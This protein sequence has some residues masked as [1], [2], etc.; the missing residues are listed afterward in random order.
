MKGKLLIK[1]RRFLAA[2]GASAAVGPFF[3]VTPAKADK[4]ELVVVSWG[5]TWA[6][7]MREVMFAPF[8]R[9]TGFKVRDDGPPEGAKL[10]AMIQGGNVTWDVLDTDLPAIQTMVKDGL[11]DALDYS[12]LAKA[13]LDHIPKVL[14]SSHAVGHKIYSF[15]IVYNTK[16]FPTGK[17]PKSW[18][19]VW[20]G[21]KFKGGRS[22]AFRGGISPQ[23][24]IALLADGV[25]I[26][27][28]NPLDVER[29]WKSM[30][31]L[32]PL[33]TKWYTGHAEAI[34]LVS[35]GEVDIACTVGPRGI[36]AK[37]AGAPVDVEYNQG[38]LGSDYWCLV[39]G[40]QNK[41]M[42][43]KFIDFALDAKRQA[44][45]VKE[46][47]YGPSHAK[48]FDHLTKEEARDL[49]TSPDN[50]G[51]QFWIDEEWWGKVGPDGKNQNEK[52]KERFAQWMLRK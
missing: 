3:H 25:P 45:M 17:H 2:A 13:N 29:A 37:R 49:T 47:P 50:I 16:T 18:A 6:K 27:K 52:Q 30:D 8:E 26:D 42:A 46:N 23:L 4:G 44:G 7:T 28:L 36:T 11:L 19:E 21:A 51:R 9:E 48:A 43:M 34:Q 12:K 35:S 14:Q 5:G 40:S 1:R 10:K 33:V 31:K 38:K 15:N 41:D 39:K 32:K 20:D 22:F 24:E